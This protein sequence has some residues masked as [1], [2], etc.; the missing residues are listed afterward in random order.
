M[1]FFPKQIDRPSKEKSNR[2]GANVETDA[3]SRRRQKAVDREIGEN[4]IRIFVEQAVD[5]GRGYHGWGRGCSRRPDELV[6][7]GSHVNNKTNTNII[8][9]AFSPSF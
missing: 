6:Q 1:I 3:R 9:L 7:Q 2:R 5:R 4:G 8:F